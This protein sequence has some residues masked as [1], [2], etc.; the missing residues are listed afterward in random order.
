MGGTGACPGV[1]RAVAGP[2]VG[3]AVPRGVSQVAVGQVVF[4]QVSFDEWDC[5]PPSWLFGLRCLNTG[6]YNG[7]LG[8]ARRW[9]QDPQQDVYLQSEF[10]SL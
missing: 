7:Q 4:R 10:T 9:C 6:A 8:G 2:L 3:Q 5:A 1:G